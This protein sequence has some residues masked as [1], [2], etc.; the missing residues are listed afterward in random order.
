MNSNNVTFEWTKDGRFLHNGKERN[1][2]FLRDQTL[3]VIFADDHRDQLVF[4]DELT[5]FKQLI[6][7]GPDQFEGRRLK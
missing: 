7:G 4:D 2:R 5:T 6:R 3:E 1:W